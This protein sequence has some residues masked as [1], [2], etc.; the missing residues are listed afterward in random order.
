MC[1]MYALIATVW[2]V[3][4]RKN[5]KVWHVRSTLSLWWS[6]CTRTMPANLM[7]QPIRSLYA[8]MPYSYMPMYIPYAY[9]RAICPHTPYMPTCVIYALNLWHTCTKCSGMVLNMCYMPLYVSLYVSLFMPEYGRV[10][11]RCARIWQGW[12]VFYHIFYN[13]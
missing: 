8:Y 6:I 9:I 5:A 12:H 10:G 13:I 3:S 4:T 11:L 1:E 7:L 2:G